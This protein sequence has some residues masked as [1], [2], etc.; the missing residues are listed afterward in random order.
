MELPRD[1]HDAIRWAWL[2]YFIVGLCFCLAAQ[3]IFWMGLGQ[4]G[5]LAWPFIWAYSQ[6]ALIE[7]ATGDV[8]QTL[9]AVLWTVA[10]ALMALLLWV[11]LERRRQENR[12]VWRRAVATWVA[13]QLALGC[14]A[15]GLW[16]AG[17]VRME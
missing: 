6:V 8:G 7:S 13:L 17:V 2:P 11:G 3:G 4:P 15:Y 12:G 1:P 16:L 14:L 10:Y 5:V 9:F